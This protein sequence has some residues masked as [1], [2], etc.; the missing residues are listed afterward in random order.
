MTP[1][2]VWTKE[3]PQ[4][5]HLRVFGCEAYTHIPKDER[6]KL[7]AKAKKCIL[8]G[9]GKE[10]K[11]YRLYDPSGVK[12]FFSRDVFKENDIDNEVEATDFGGE[13]RIELDV[14]T[15]EAQLESDSD[16]TALESGS[17]SPAPVDPA[18]ESSSPTPR[19]PL[20]P[21]ARRSVRPRNFPDYCG[22]SANLVKA[23]PSTVEEA[24]NTPEKD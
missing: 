22:L 14:L 19:Q 4:V 11:G 7:D 5:G 16:A 8:V 15:N 1:Y 12:I 3:K 20:P 24:M 23:E 10:T 18:I 2:E 9:Y 21:T 17:T 6:R 13:E